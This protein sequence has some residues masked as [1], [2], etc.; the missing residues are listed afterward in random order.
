MTDSKEIRVFPV[1]E[2][3]RDEIN[4]CFSTFHGNLITDKEICRKEFNLWLKQGYRG[5]G[6]LPYYVEMLAQHLPNRTQQIIFRNLALDAITL[7]KTGSISA[8]EVSFF[9]KH[10]FTIF[11]NLL[12]LIIMGSILFFYSAK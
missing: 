1:V 12:A 5:P 4:F 7:K 3:I 8:R 9:A 6:K 11:F 10:K 2:R